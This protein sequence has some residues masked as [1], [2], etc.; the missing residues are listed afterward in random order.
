M[1]EWEKQFFDRPR[2]RAAAHTAK[3]GSDYPA[4][5]GAPPRQNYT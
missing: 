5:G 1:V 2:P 3:T 4:P